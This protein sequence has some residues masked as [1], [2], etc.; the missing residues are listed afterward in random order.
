[1]N[2]NIQN[3]Y[4]FFCLEIYIFYLESKSQYYLKA[5]MKNDMQQPNN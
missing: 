5:K 4:L 1:M 3:N 2:I